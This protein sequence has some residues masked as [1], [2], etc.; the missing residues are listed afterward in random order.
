[1]PDVYMTG[2]SASFGDLTVTIIGGRTLVRALGKLAPD[3]QRAIRGEIKRAGDIVR[4]KASGYGASLGRRPSGA[5]AGSF[6]VRALAG[7][8]RVQSDDPGA[9]TIEFAKAGAVYLRGPLY[10]M[11]IGTPGDPKPRALIRAANEEEPTVIAAVQ[12]AIQ[13]ACDAVGGA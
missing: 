6:S 11:P 8:V 3:A 5:Y 2:T 1:M 13:R 4:S 7:G 12:N 9:G 10:G